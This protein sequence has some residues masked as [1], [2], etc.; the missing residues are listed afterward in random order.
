MLHKSRH[1]SLHSGL[2]ILA[3]LALAI[4]LRAPLHAQ[5]TPPSPQVLILYDTG[6][7]ADSTDWLGRMHAQFLQNLLGHF[8]ARVTTKRMD[9]YQPGDL[10][11]FDAAFYMGGVY[12]APL[13][14]D[15]QQEV[16][17]STHPL[18]WLYCNI[19]KLAW[20]QAEGKTVDNPAFL[21]RYGFRFVGNDEGKYTEFQYRVSHL[22]KSDAEPTLGRV[23]IIDPAKAQV[24]ATCAQVDRF[25]VPYI[26]HAANL[27]YFGDNPLQDVTDTDRHLIFADV[28]HEILGIHH[29]ANHRA[30]VRIE[31]VHPL[32]SP[33]RLRQV[34]DLCKSL[35]VPF[36]VC[37]IPVFRDPAGAYNDGVRQTVL[38][39]DK[40]KFVAALRYMQQCGGQLVLHGYTHQYGNVLNP[41]SGAT[42]DDV[43]F[44]RQTVNAK[45]EVIS[46][47]VPHDSA[48]WAKARVVQAQRLLAQCHLR[49]VA[50]NTPHYLASATDYR[51]FAK[52]FS[53]FVDHGQYY[54]TD[55]AGV[56]HSDDQT[57]PYVLRD[58]YGCLRIP[59]NLGFLKFESDGEDDPIQKP[60]D[61]MHKA[62]ANL[63]VRDGW[64]SFFYHCDID[65]HALKESILRIK[66]LGYHFVPITTVTGDVRTWQ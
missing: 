40:P 24:V 55:Q 39:T 61:L 58:L 48:Q 31:D 37:V 59:E 66:S 29:R 6:S 34:A 44:Y 2:H 15:F 30:V 50:W 41:V 47:P 56:L 63:T 16:L 18:C 22:T 57:P 21:Q 25:P 13:P 36:S 64:A 49:A 12:D 27:W 35:G 4:G 53:L 5:P 9:A 17:T 62:Q 51:Q 11:R 32:L 20:V 42:G 43:E 10:Q 28:L 52:M 7:A 3:V 45:G 14:A 1:L 60:I 26:T 23:A 54:V 33:T 19:W 65:L 46:A 8:A 38:M